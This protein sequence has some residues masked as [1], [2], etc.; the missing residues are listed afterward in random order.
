MSTILKALKRSEASRPRE[1]SLPLGQVPDSGTARHRGTGFWLAGSLLVVALGAAGAWWM[2][3][4]PAAE[5]GG[6]RPGLRD[7]AEVSL[8][9]RSAGP[10]GDEPASRSSERPALSDPGS[11]AAETEESGSGS[12]ATG[13]VAAESGESATKRRPAPEGATR[14]GE[15]GSEEAS[16]SPARRETA[17]DE[18]GAPPGQRLERFA[19]LPRIGDL[20]PER[21]KRLPRLAL[22]AHVHTGEPGKRFVLINLSRYGEGDRVAPGLTVARIFPGGVVL[23][24]GQGR[25]VLPRP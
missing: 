8:P 18:A 1:A 23:E 14:P 13:D 3:Q 4:H 24:D 12:E 10:A 20:P 19:L 17:T 5:T 16:A 21:R 7:I 11:R 22:N 15:G 25:F 9:A 6:S 2:N